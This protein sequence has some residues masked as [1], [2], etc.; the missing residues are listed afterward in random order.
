MT[1]APQIN[2]LDVA[3]EVTE[4][5]NKFPGTF[6]TKKYILF[7]EKNIAMLALNPLEKVL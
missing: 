1:P 7:T 2:T 6:S 5:L 4:L 3:H